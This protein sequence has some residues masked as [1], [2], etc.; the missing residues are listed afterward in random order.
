MIVDFQ[1][2]FIPPELAKEP[3]GTKTA[4][5]F[6]KDGVPSMTPNSV[7]YDLDEHIRMMD[8]AGI[9]A[10]FL[11]SPPGMC[12]DTELS[13]L[14]NDK[15]KAAE[16]DYP[17]RFIGGAHA[18]PLGGPDALREL[19]RCSVELGFPGVV[20]T[21]EIDGTFIHDAALQPFWTDPVPLAIFAFI[22]PPP[23]LHSPP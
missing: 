3:A 23:N 4:I 6:D 15:T 19:K 18:N 8:A 2:H 10:A 9:D 11:T 21:T 13:R 1:H 20:I 17:G 12:V 22:P 14:I 7:L 5:R 16:K